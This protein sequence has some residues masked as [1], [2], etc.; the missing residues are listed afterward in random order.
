M[1]KLVVAGSD[2]PEIDL[3]ELQKGWTKQGISFSFAKLIG[4][5]DINEDN[6]LAFGQWSK[7]CDRVV[8]AEDWQN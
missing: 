1:L 5:Y 2:E 8:R 4:D 3:D 6:P 7:T